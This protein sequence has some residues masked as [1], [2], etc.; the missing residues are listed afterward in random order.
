[1]KNSYLLGLSDEELVKSIHLF[2]VDSVD[3][4]EF[5]LN[6]LK[7]LVDDD[8]LYNFHSN[9]FLLVSW[10]LPLLRLIKLNNS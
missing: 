6:N 7:K 8:F 4:F 3:D 5:D 1:M 2:F 9:R 10:V